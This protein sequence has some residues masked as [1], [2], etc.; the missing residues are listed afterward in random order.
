VAIW[1]LDTALFIISQV[2][3]GVVATVVGSD[4]AVAVGGSGCKMGGCGLRW[5]AV[6]WPGRECHCSEGAGGGC[7]AGEEVVVMVANVVD[8]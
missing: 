8:C 1:V 3:A 5:G 2:V 4:M 6:G 7:E